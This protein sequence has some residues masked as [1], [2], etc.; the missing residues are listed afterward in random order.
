MITCLFGSKLLFEVTFLHAEG[1]EA[2]VTSGI[3][4]A[5]LQVLE[6]KAY[7]PLNITVSGAM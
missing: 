3:M 4:K 7:E 2:L 6:W 5:L 1:G